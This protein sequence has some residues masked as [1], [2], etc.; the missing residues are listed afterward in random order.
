MISL[1]ICSTW[2]PFVR[3][4]ELGSYSGACKEVRDLSS[5]LC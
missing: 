3:C 5:L 1:S 4:R 2:C